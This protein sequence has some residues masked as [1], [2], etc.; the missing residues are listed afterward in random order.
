MLIVAPSVTQACN[1][2]EQVQPMLE[3]IAALAPVLGQAKQLLAESG[4]E[5]HEVKILA[6]ADAAAQQLA[7]LLQAQ[8]QAVGFKPVIADDLKEMDSRIFFDRP[9]GLRF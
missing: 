2:K 7:L 6:T 9:M 5:G 8:W 1:D 4:M 3:R